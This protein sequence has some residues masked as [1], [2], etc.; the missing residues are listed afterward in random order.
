MINW[1]PA[2]IPGWAPLW[3]DSGDESTRAWFRNNP[4]AEWYYNSIYINGSPA[5]EHHMDKYGKKFS[6]EDFIPLFNESADK[7]NAFEW[8][9]A[10]RRAGAKYVIVT[11][12]HHDGYCLWPTKL[13]NPRRKTNHPDKDILGELASEVRA[14]GMKFGVYYSGGLDVTFNDSV[15]TDMDWL[16]NAIPSTEDYAEYVDAQYRELIDLYA[17]DIL[18][19]D[20]AVPQSLDIDS[21]LEYYYSRV[22]Q[23]V[24]NDRFR[25]ITS[26]DG[27]NEIQA[28]ELLPSFTAK[29]RDA[30][31][32]V[33]RRGANDFI[34]IERNLHHGEI[35][36]KWELTRGL[37]RSHFHNINETP[38]TAITPDA[39]IKL[40]IEITGGGGNLL[41]SIGPDDQGRIPAY[42]R[43]T[44]AGLGDYIGLKDSI[45]IF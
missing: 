6:Y 45:E 21:L 13:E 32:S 14:I 19:N 23:G 16:V 31:S 43:D 39:L 1:G 25:K 2:S 37:T 26:D 33:L 18:W 24:V 44:I 10:C 17:P 28:M 41:V 40:F 36:Q 20:I 42:A 15:I 8:V 27:L 30:G 9:S 12:K 11:A 3:N 34:C 38:Q 22:P 5:Q 4:Y 7:W 29:F 35:K